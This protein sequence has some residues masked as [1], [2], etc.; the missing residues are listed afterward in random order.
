MK[1]QYKTKLAPSE[2]QN[3]TKQLLIKTSTVL[4]I[5][6]YVTVLILILFSGNSETREEAKFMVSVRN[7]LVYTVLVFTF[8]IYLINERK[9]VIKENLNKLDKFINTKSHGIFVSAFLI[10][11]PIIAFCAL[12]INY[13][14]LIQG[15]K[16]LSNEQ[17]L[18]LI[19]QVYLWLLC[20]V[21]GMLISTHKGYTITF[22]LFVYVLVFYR[23]DNVLQDNYPSLA[24]W[25]RVD[26]LNIVENILG[27]GY[28]IIIT[29]L[30]EGNQQFGKLTPKTML[31]IFNLSSLFMVGTYLHEGINSL[32]MPILP[33]SLLLI[34][35]SK[36]IPYKN[37]FFKND[38]FH[39]S[40]RY[41][42]LV[43][44]LYFFY[45]AY[46]FSA[47]KKAPHMD[48]TT[49]LIV[50]LIILLIMFGRF[51]SIKRVI[52]LAAPL[53]LSNTADGMESEHELEGDDELN[54]G[55]N[56]IKS[57]TPSE[58]SIDN[59][60]ENTQEIKSVPDV[61]RNKERRKKA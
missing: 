16:T 60:R 61:H 53:S 2:E 7:I 27:I 51:D 29:L 49:I 57:A 13:H 33:I 50:L 47:G 6:Y 15:S 17:I 23:W 26:N 55:E 30:G 14:D 45:A 18:I 31:I 9:G 37:V 20:I 36:I 25:F 59:N 28:G 39:I 32:N 44:C 8:L 22:S 11:A 4:L 52:S 12:R 42:Q 5:L 34:I 38:K 48:V 3:K 40:T 54:E 41:A 56:S 21:I 10:F 43:M 1:T 46:F 35:S 19:Q 24:L 58:K